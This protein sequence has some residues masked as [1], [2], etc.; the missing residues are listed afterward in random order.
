[1]PLR[2]EIEEL[3][4]RESREYSA[5]DRA[6]FADFKEALNRGRVRA[7][8]RGD[9]GAWRVNSWVKRGILLGFRM[10]QLK[11]MSV[12]GGDVLRF[13]D[14]D[15]YPP[16]ATRIEE[17]VRIVPGGSSIR[18]GA[19]VAPTVVCMPPMYINVGAYVDEGTMIDSHA[20]VG[21]CA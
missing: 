21:S 2:D 19:Y 9:D 13:F 11:D 15:T 3:A 20:L 5:G 14:K 18:D 1:M 16:R 6:L 12:A 10:G 4:A 7:A 17:N 8:E